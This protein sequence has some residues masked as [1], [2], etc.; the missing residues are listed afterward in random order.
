MNGKIVKRDD[1]IMGQNP[2]EITSITAEQKAQMHREE[3]KK[4]N[5]PKVNV[6][7]DE[8]GNITQVE[9]ICSCGEV[10]KLE[11]KYES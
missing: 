11:C 6:T 5:I 8:T 3:N 4:K 2:I 7:R 9:V 1:L 10:I